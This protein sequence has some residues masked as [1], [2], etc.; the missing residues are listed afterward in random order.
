MPP[1]CSR[2]VSDERNEGLTPSQ[3][4]T[5]DRT[6][7][8]ARVR[9]WLDANAPR[10]G[11]PD[12]FSSVHL[13]SATTAEGYEEKER[14]ALEVTRAWQRRRFDAGLA[15]R[16]WPTEYG[17]RG[18]PSW[19]DDIIAEEQSAYGVSTKALAIALE[20]APPV[21]FQYGTH[22]QRSRHLPR[23]VRGD[24][25][26][27]QL[28]SEPDAGSDLAS[29]STIAKPVDGGWLVSG[30][31]VWTSGAG[32]AN[33]ALLM[34]RTDRDAP[35]QAGL[36]FLAFDMSQPG[37]EVRPLRQMNGAYHFNEVFIEDVF[38][39]TDALIGTPGGAWTVMRTMLAS[40]RSAIGGGTSARSAQQL[41][42]LARQLGRTEEPSV[43]Q[44]VAGAH[45]REWILDL[46]TAR[47]RST[48]SDAAGPIGKLMYSEHARKSANDAMSLLGASGLANSEISEPWL[49]RLLFA[50]GATTRRRHRRDPAQH[51]RRARTRTPPRT[52]PLT[53]DRYRTGGMRQRI[54]RR[55]NSHMP[56]LS[57]RSSV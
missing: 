39:P 44:L 2:S 7:F 38:V 28:L 6:E 54:R 5:D 23:I 56:P 40:E 19:Q 50:P 21:L 53:F 11:A 12:D 4:D 25:S 31:K 57:T 15:C 22:E 14:H 47:F 35:R 8:R 33:F 1:E 43:R 16:S 32:S 48:P 18:A 34:A 20:M 13:V 30:Q 46:T 9:R 29:V 41:I 17:G 45:A 55:T 24:E 27:C 52:A 37:V 42:A 36:S 10:K 3:F 51:H 26:W 49:D